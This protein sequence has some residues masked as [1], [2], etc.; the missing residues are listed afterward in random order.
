L[1]WYQPGLDTPSDGVPLQQ[2][3]TPQAKFLRGE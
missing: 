2:T 1:N 3:D